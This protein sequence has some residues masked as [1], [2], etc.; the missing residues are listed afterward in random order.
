[1]KKTLL[2]FTLAALALA[3][4]VFAQQIPRKATEFAIKMPN[5][6]ETLLSSF[7]GKVILL[8]FLFTT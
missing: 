4:A 3:Q 7:R 1:L 8:E 5:G 2:L 6:T